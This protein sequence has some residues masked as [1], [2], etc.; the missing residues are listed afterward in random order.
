MPTTPKS[1]R[2]QLEATLKPLLPKAWRFVPYQTTLD[3]LD[4]LTVMV[5]QSGVKRY[6]PAPGAYRLHEFTVSLI[7]SKIDPQQAEDDLDQAVETFLDALEGVNGG[8]SLALSQVD[9]NRVYGESNFAS[10]ITL[11]T[12]FR[13]A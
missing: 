12:T 7:S 6:D 1:T 2:A 5:K 4:R 10:D 3:T 13:K 9:T 8:Q 11:T